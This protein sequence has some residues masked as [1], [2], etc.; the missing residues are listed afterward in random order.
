MEKITR[1][2]FQPALQPLNK[3]AIKNVG[4]ISRQQIKGFDSSKPVKVQ[5]MGSQ[6]NFNG[7]SANGLSESALSIS[8][9]GISGTSNVNVIGSTKTVVKLKKPAAQNSIETT[10]SQKP[11]IPKPSSSSSK[12]RETLGSQ[13]SGNQ[14]NKSNLNTFQLGQQDDY[15]DL[16][17]GDEDSRMEE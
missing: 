6:E 14:L 16:M 1:G 4:N 12:S 2:N 7:A 15:A 9:S 10:N 11:V 17:V 8:G 3:E 5:A 13:K